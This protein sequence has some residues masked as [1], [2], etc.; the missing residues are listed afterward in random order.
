MKTDHR[1]ERIL[2][3]IARFSAEY[4]ARETGGHS[5]ITVTRVEL[6]D[7]LKYA[8]IFFT[9]YPESEE[10]AALKFLQRRTNDMRGYID[11]HVRMAQVPRLK[12]EIDWGEKNRQKIEDI[13][14]KDQKRK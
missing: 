12:C 11:E 2:S 13:S 5:L 9:V 1:S 7:T 8:T 14:A 3:L 4:I 10:E 6:S